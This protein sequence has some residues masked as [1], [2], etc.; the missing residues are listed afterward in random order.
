M[1]YISTYYYASLLKELCCDEIN[2]K[3]MAETMFIVETNIE[4]DQQRSVHWS[5]F[6]GE[7]YN[8]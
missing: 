5:R 2:Q 1:G 3:I 6:L 4:N 7:L 8:Y